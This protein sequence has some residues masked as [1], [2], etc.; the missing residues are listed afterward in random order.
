MIIHQAA[1]IYVASS[2]DHAEVPRFLDIADTLFPSL[3][4]LRIGI[5]D[6]ASEEPGATLRVCAILAFVFSL[7]AIL[8]IIHC[9]TFTFITGNW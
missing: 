6:T 1:Q 8:L 3:S 9:R 7:H 4:E 5:S 2:E